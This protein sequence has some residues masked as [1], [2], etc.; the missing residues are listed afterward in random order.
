MR[1]ALYFEASDV[2]AINNTLIASPIAGGAAINDYATKP[3]IEKQHYYRS[4]P[5]DCSPQYI[6]LRVRELQQLLP[7]F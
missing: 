3:V 2:S 6:E 7:D 1:D 5:G 4:K